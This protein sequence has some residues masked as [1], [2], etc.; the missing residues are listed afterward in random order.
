MLLQYP[1]SYSVI[2]MNHEFEQYSDQVN[3]ENIRKYWNCVKP[4]GYMV[5]KTLDYSRKTNVNGILNV[6][7]IRSCT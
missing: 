4:E 5:I 6:S 3:I 7:H 2:V 1:L